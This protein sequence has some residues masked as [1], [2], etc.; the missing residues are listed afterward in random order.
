MLVL[1]WYHGLEEVHSNHWY[2]F[3]KRVIRDNEFPRKIATC[4]H[5]TDA[6]Y[7]SIKQLLTSQRA[8]INKI[9]LQ[10]RLRFDPYLQK[11]AINWDAIFCNFFLKDAAIICLIDMILY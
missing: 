11:Y 1:V 7:S 10:L 5:R 2:Q 4:I 8:K 6:S 3:H 9:G